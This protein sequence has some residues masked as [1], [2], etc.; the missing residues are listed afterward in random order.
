MPVGLIAS[1]PHAWL[2]RAQQGKFGAEAYEQPDFLS[3]FNKTDV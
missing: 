3:K 2:L 1:V